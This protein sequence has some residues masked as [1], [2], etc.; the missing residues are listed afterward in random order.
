MLLSKQVRTLVYGFDQISDAGN[1]PESQ[2]K[3]N[4]R[5]ATPTPDSLANE[6]ADPSSAS[7]NVIA[8]IFALKVQDRPINIPYSP[9]S[10]E[11]S[12]QHSEEV[13]ATDTREP[14]QT[15]IPR[16][17]SSHPTKAEIE[18][19]M[20]GTTYWKGSWTSPLVLVRETEGKNIFRRRHCKLP[21]RCSTCPP[22]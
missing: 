12:P 8:K 10:P 2:V 3:N 6:Y 4:V 1:P 14:M 15:S 9:M 18:A 16:R 21:A 13:E 20:G 7:V 19:A 17:R 11:D 5:P 22:I